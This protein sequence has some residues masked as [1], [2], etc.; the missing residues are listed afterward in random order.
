[1]VEWTGTTPLAE[2]EELAH[3]KDLDELRE[4]ITRLQDRQATT[5]MAQMETLLGK[6]RE[7]EEENR[8]LKQ[9]IKRLSATIGSIGESISEL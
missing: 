4:G 9:V 1:M 6:N 5:D 3:R 8:E 2:Q 7:L